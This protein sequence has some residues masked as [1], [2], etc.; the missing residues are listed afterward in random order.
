M[1]DEPETRINPH[2]RFDKQT[3]RRRLAEIT[4]SVP[5]ANPSRATLQSVH[6]F[7]MPQ[8]D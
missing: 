1:T 5:D 6:A 4:T 7:L 2:R 8:D 3:I